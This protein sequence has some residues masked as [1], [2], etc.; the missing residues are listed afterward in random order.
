MQHNESWSPVSRFLIVT[1][2]IV[3]VVA[4][5]GAAAEILVPVL[6]AVILAMAL[7][8]GFRWLQR[9]GVPGGLA[10]LLLILALLM[11][12]SAVSAA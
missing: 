8:P 6:F 9:N 5:L 3:I 1:A 7:A 4:G 10:I 2:S 11:W 12:A